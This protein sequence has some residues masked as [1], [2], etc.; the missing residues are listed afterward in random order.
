MRSRS[1]SASSCRTFR[2]SGSMLRFT[3]ACV[4]TC[5]AESANLMVDTDSSALEATG[6]SVAMT[7]VLALPPRLS[8]ISC[9]SLLLRYGMNFSPV[10]SAEMTSPS[11]DRDLLMACASF[12]RSALAPVLP[13]RSLP[14][15]STRLSLPVVIF[16][17]CLLYTSMSTE[18]MRCEREDSAF[19]LVAPTCRAPLPASKSVRISPASAASLMMALVM[20]TMPFLS[21]LMSSFAGA[22]LLSFLSM[23]QNRS[24]SESLYS[25][26]M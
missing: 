20:Y 11:A 5:F 25:S 22:P 4:M 13:T 3:R 24:T 10:E 23:V 26:T 21:F 6:D 16:L 12:S 2:R 17:V 7:R 15:R 1:T 19:I 9:V 14:A 8:L 18:K